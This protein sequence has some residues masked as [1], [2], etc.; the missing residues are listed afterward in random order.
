[1]IYVHSE[2]SLGLSTYELLP[3][4]VCFTYSLSKPCSYDCGKSIAH[5]QMDSA[6]DGSESET[7]S[8]SSE[9]RASAPVSFKL[10]I[11]LVPEIENKQSNGLCMSCWSDGWKKCHVS[12][13]NQRRKRSHWRKC[14]EASN[15]QIQRY[16]TVIQII[17][18]FAKSMGLWTYLQE[19]ID[20]PIPQHDFQELH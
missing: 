2:Q 8:M 19:N 14:L 3:F 11:I 5:H 9:P 16:D 10:S 12:Q 15:C 1:M 20:R 13:F 7:V 17:S 4:L 18:V 6:C